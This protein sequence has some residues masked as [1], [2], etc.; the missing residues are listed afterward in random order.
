M[1]ASTVSRLLSSAVTGD[2]VGL[3]PRVPAAIRLDYERLNLS[4]S[5]FL[6]PVIFTKVLEHC[7]LSL[8][9]TVSGECSKMV[10]I[11]V[12]AEDTFFSNARWG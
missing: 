1:A 5:G 7:V 10:V 11:G 9:M 6:L 8:Y 4:V 3:L 2:R 12:L